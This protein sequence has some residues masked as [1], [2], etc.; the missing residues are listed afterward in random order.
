MNPRQVLIYFIPIQ[1]TTKQFFVHICFICSLYLC[2]HYFKVSLCV[3]KIH[4]CWTVYIVL[5]SMFYHN[6][7]TASPSNHIRKLQHNCPDI[8]KKNS[9]YFCKFRTHKIYWDFLL[10]NEWK[11]IFIWLLYLML[12]F[13]NKKFSVVS[14]EQCTGLEIQRFWTLT[15]GGKTKR[16][17]KKEHLWF[18]IRPKN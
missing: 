14:R 10:K 9:T 18:Q 4:R 17:R 11:I 3:L 16:N 2:F 7:F 1:A 12:C 15:E 13:E 6:T 8:C 5:L